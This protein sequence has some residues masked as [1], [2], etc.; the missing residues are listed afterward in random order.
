[1][2]ALKRS[3][4]NPFAGL[5]LERFGEQRELFDPQ[6]FSGELRY[7][8]ALSDGRIRT[9][10]AGPE[11][12]WE[13]QRGESEHVLLGHHEGILYA[14]QW[15]TA[16]VDGA[17]PP[18]EQ[19]YPDLRAHAQL[20]DPFQAGLA[21]YAR[22]MVIWHQRHRYCGLCGSATQSESHG[23]RRRCT[24]KACASE[25]FP[26]IDPAI[27]VAVSC[28]ERL[29]LARQSNWPEK[30]YS[31]LAGFVEPG[32]SLEDCVRREVF[33]ESGIRVHDCDYHSSQ[34]WPFP[35]GLMLG[36][37]AH[38]DDE[39]LRLDD[40]L[41]HALWLNP[42]QLVAAIANNE[43]RPPSGFS[44]SRRLVEDWYTELRGGRLGVAV[45]SYRANRQS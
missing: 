25:H 19:P 35:S 31:V 22:A 40:E 1:M 3:N 17:L 33:E 18:P 11:L 7:L 36:F 14:V 16:T 27:I 42:E 32:E 9:Q 12:Y 45:S 23:H 29:L 2:S 26:R 28:G 44:I 30:R 5:P 10:S 39:A 6:S 37:T 38:T 21:A 4:R 15:S 41:E 13:S 8:Q 20:L 24:A 34:P 43:L